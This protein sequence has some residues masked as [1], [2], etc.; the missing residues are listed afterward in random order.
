VTGA[1]RYTVLRLATTGSYAAIARSTTTSY[2]DATAHNGTAYTYEVTASNSAGT[3]PASPSATATPSAKIADTAR[4]NF[5]TSA[6]GWTSLGSMAMASGV[7]WS[8][9]YAGGYSFGAQ[10]NSPAGG[11]KIDLYVPNA[12]P[13][14]GATVTFHVWI[15]AGSTLVSVQPYLLE[16]ASTGWKWTGNWQ[17]IAHL[18]ANAWNTITVKVPSTAKLPL[19]QLG[20]EFATSDVWTG[21]V[22]VD[23]VTW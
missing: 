11:G 5:E 1:T 18:K 17:P 3:G 6:Q 8:E 12:G 10:I 20:V 7:S 13:G 9:A 19:S 2:T 14:R 15:P 16:N 21:S 22:Y 23:S 4:Y